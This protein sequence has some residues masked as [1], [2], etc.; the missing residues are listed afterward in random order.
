MN[1]TV[2]RLNSLVPVA[3]NVLQNARNSTVNAINSG[4]GASSVSW[5]TPLMWFVGFLIIFL[6][7]FGMYYYQFME[8]LQ[9]WSDSLNLWFTGKGSPE[10]S[11][12]FKSN[13]VL[14]TSTTDDDA[15]KQ[16][17][18]MD[19]IV[20]K[21]LP[22]AKDVFTVSKNDFT[23]YDAAPLCK[24]L[25]AELATYDEVK[26][27]WHKGADWCN[28]GW[29]KGQMAVYPTQ[30]STY[31]E[32]QQGPADQRGVCGKPGLNGGYFDNP[33]LKFGVTCSGKRPSQTDH[34]ATAITSGATRPLTASGIE[35]EKKVQRFKEE[36]ETVGVLPFNKERWSS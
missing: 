9:N 17:T 24:A 34:D 15:T 8:S 22:P 2:Q 13:P 29:V 28:Y 23:Y 35:F 32:L 19:A 6:A 3:G 31:E 4:Y 14:Q 12:V 10:N 27:A 25:G 11:N 5:N 33:E 21:V 20:E 30:K 1:S 36:S 7:L 16:P 18:G 26:R